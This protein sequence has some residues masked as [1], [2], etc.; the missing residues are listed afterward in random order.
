MRRTL[1]HT[2]T[3]KRERKKYHSSTSATIFWSGWLKGAFLGTGDGALVHCTQQLV[4]THFTP[5]EH[6]YNNMLSRLKCKQF[7]RNKWIIFRKYLLFVRCYWCWLPS[8]IMLLTLTGQKILTNIFR[9]V[10]VFLL[11]LRVC[12]CCS[13]P[14]FFCLRFPPRHWMF[15]LRFAVASVAFD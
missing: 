7:L 3:T 5:T 9:I 2:Y 14:W 8:S 12:R 6:N 15:S 10:A 1:S 13:H 11:F 4:F